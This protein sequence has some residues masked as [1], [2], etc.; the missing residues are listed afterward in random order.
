MTV[1]DAKQIEKLVGELKPKIL[2]AIDKLPRVSGAKGCELA[3]ESSIV[4][5]NQKP[6]GAVG[7]SSGAG[8]VLDRAPN[9]SAVQLGRCS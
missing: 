3:P 7:T 2:A 5:R 4:K 1:G 9:P 8:G 6:D